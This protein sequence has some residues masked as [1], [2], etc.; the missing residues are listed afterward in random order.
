VTTRFHPFLERVLIAAF[1][2]I[3]TLPALGTMMGV[4]RTTATD[5]NRPLEPFPRLEMTWA[6]WQ[7]FP[8]GFTRYFE[9]NFAF[10]PVLVRGQAAARLKALDVSPSRSV[11]KGRDGWWFYADDG[12][13]EDYAEAPPFTVPELEAWRRTL[14][15]TSDWLRAR[16][17]AYVFVMAP[18]K[19]Q[20][21]PEHMPS[22]I[23][24]AAHSR[25]DQLARYLADHS[26]VRVLDLRP[27]LTRA[28]SAERIYH[29]TDTHWNDAG[30]YTAYTRILSSLSES[31]PALRPRP[32]AMLAAHHVRRGGLDLARMMRLTHVLHEDD[33]RLDW[34]GKAAA[35]IVEP[36]EPNP[37]G[38]DARLVTEL[39]DRTRPRAV[40]FRDSFGSA[41]IPFLSEHFSRAVY[42]W[43]YNVDPEVIATERPDVV[44][45][46]L[47]GRRLVTL[48]PYN[49]FEGTGRAASAPAGSTP[50]GSLASARR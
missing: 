9:D 46:E 2:V 19:H 36:R 26:T 14:Q 3:I 34:G 7:A 27:A 30:A 20:V 42:L 29:L 39:P 15:A 18:D 35:R 49:P 44:I 41:L 8:A 17:I 16:G 28:K 37:H 25:M 43:Q 48:T 10:R 50:A 31:V 5:E 38:I 45:H 23:R 33:V 40:I 21:Y 47:V 1:L 4:Q 22:T 12:A 24:R 6:S 11:I 13:L 32:R